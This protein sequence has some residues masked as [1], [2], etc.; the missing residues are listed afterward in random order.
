VVSTLREVQV[1]IGGPNR[2]RKERVIYAT[3][4]RED[5]AEIVVA[6]WGTVET[7]HVRIAKRRIASMIFAEDVSARAWVR[8]CGEQ[9]ERWPAYASIG[10]RDATSHQTMLDSQ[11]KKRAKRAHT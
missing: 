9:A 2:G 3:L 6:P 11:K 7:F 5:D 10:A 1:S 8:I 4:L